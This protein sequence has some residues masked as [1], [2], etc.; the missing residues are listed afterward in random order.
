MKELL[1]TK[2]A[3]CAA[4]GVAPATIDRWRFHEDYAYL[5]FPRAVKIGFKVFWRPSDIE[6]WAEAQLTKDDTP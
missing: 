4:L 5:A 2:K 6:D 1:L 3:V